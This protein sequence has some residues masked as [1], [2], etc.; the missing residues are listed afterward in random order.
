MS[1]NFS[2]G[3]KSKD[4]KCYL[5]GYEGKKVYVCKDG[6]HRCRKCLGRLGKRGVKDEGHEIDP[7]ATARARGEIPP[8]D[9]PPQ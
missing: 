7:M 6:N 9:E 5:C 1:L 2:F 8:T 4:L 3:R